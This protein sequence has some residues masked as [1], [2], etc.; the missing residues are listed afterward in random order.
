MPFR[1][2]RRSGESPT[3]TRRALVVYCLAIVVPTVLLLALGLQAVRRQ[4]DAIQGLTDANARLQEARLVD[5]VE[6]RARELAEAALRDPELAGVLLT[7]DWQHPGEAAAGARRLDRARARHPIV[8]HTF[9]V[10]DDGVAFPRVLEPLPLSIAGLVAEEPAPRRATLASLLADADAAER[11]GAP[12]RAA[13]RYARAA[14]IAHT[15]RLRAIALMRLARV[16]E[17]LGEH[18]R[19]VAAHARVVAEAGDAH[20]L[21]GRPAV[22]VSGL[23]LARLTTGAAAGAGV[24]RAAADA[25][26]PAGLVIRL[27]RELCSGRWELTA[28]QADYF[29]AELARLDRA[30]TEPRSSPLLDRLALGRAVEAAFDRV[31]TIEPGRLHA[32][33]LAAGGVRRQVFYTRADPGAPDPHVIG[34]AADESWVRRMLVPDTARELGLVGRPAILAV[35]GADHRGTP[36]RLAFPNWRVAIEPGGDA[37]RWLSRESIAFGATTLSVL[38]LLVLGVVFLTRD[39]ARDAATSRMRA[40]LVSGVSHELKTPLSVIRVY[41]ET[42]AAD[43]DTAREER[44]SYYDI[45]LQESERLTHLIE[46]VLEFA[47]VERGLRRYQLVPVDLGAL[48]ASVVDRYRP[49]LASLGFTLETTIAEGLPAVRADAAAVAQALVNLLDNAL[50]YSGEST[51]IEIRLA[52]RDA[53]VVVEV[54]DHGIGLTE[55]DRTR[56]LAP[57]YR[58]PGTGRGGYGLG[59]HLVN[60]VMEG[61]GGRVEVESE[62]GRGSTF[63]LV[64]PLDAAP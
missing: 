24:V 34:I 6:E 29:L 23:E 41:A 4:R 8:E 47:R 44:R 16:H 49:Y 13:P 52:P 21:A 50:K 53:S 5:R 12:A 17:R 48:A 59:L 55:P 42:L 63:R 28:G 32:A 33:V 25:G 64:F 35:E 14:Q 57:F 37:P 2:M 18:D 60:H 51:S 45:I 26:A 3:R 43:P 20:D 10:G 36:F 11:S 30:P 58:V 62:P 39:V 46:R 22:L 40:D 9:V 1:S 54:R 27:R 31:R 7:T 38:G 15:G 19:A 61:H 56:V